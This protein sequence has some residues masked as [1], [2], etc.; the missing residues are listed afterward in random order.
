MSA[1]IY[2]SL[3]FYIKY[4]RVFF[5]VIA[6]S[7]TNSICIKILLNIDRL[8]GFISLYSNKRRPTT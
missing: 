1:E 8:T 3:G 4:E 6:S 5:C 7:S 2:I